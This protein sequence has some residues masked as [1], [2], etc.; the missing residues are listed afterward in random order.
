MNTNLV[1]KKLDEIRNCKII[2]LGRNPKNG[3]KPPKERSK[4]NKTS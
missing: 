2:N 4:I 3:G 1:I